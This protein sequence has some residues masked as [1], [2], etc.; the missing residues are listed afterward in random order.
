MGPT[1]MTKELADLNLA[2]ML[3]ARRLLRADRAAA[4][5]RLDIGP[6]IAELLAGMSLDETLRLAASNFVLCG[7]ASQPARRRS[8]P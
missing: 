5:R 1:A 4:M 2:Y 3:Q 8:P 7:A 6:D